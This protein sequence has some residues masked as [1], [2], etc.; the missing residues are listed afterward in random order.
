MRHALVLTAPGVVLVPLA[1]VHAPAL[2]AR[3]DEAMWA[4]MSTPVPRTADDVL[5]LVQ[6]TLQDVLTA[7]EVPAANEVQCGWGAHHTL[8]G[9][10]QA[11]REFLA[12]RAVWSQVTA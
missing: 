5:D 1:D 4:G 3:V 10:Q 8:D 12:Q 9:A 7:T 2:A 11:A 6:A